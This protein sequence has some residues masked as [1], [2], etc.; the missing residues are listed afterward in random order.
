V[1]TSDLLTIHT[2]QYLESLESPENISKVAEVGALKMV[3][4][5]LLKNH[6]L[7]PMLYATGGTLLGV[8]LALQ[9]GWA[10]NLGGGY[11]HAKANSGSGFCYF[12]DINLAILKLFGLKP[13]SRLMVLDLDAHQGNGVEAILAGDPRVAV[14]DVFNNDIYPGDLDAQRFIQHKF[15]LDAGC[16][17]E[18]YL[19]LLFDELPRVL[20]AEQPDFIIYNAGTDI[21]NGDP[22]GMLCVSQEGILVRDQFVFS[23]AK[24][25]GIPILMLLSGGYTPQSA[26][27]I[28]DSL[29]QI[30]P[31]MR[32]TSGA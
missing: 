1:T 32:E 21:L 9:Q 3:P 19:D 23:E 8:D 22:L 16:G 27:I 31:M 7:K 18:T 29:T 20:T 12:A 2:K 14:M 5:F 24:Q 11:H 30:I 28:A 4:A 15:P 26:G 13:K 25:R 17:T 10:I 6:L